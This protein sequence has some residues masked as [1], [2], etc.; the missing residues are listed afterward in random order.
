MGT[1]HAILCAADS[2]K[3]KLMIAFADTLFSVPSTRDGKTDF[4]LDKSKDGI[5]WV[6]KVEDPSAFGVVKVSKENIIT[7]FVEKPDTYVSDLAI[8]GIY[9]FKDGEN[10]RDELQ[11]LIDNDIKDKGEYQ[12]TNALENINKKGGTF[13]TAKVDEWLDCGNKD[14]MVYTNQRILELD[15]QKQLVADS[16]V[17]DNSTIIKPCYIGEGVVLKNSHI[18]PHASIGDKTRIEDSTISNSII[19][20]NTLIKNQVIENAMIGNYVSYTGNKNGLSIGDY[21][22]L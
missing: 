8:I 3:G 11:Y 4:K 16:V 5:I 17:V 12:L 20:T 18:G 10:L 2:L 6:K 1:A 9:Y 7:H 13:V 14:A 19:Q 15:K 22:T 21:S